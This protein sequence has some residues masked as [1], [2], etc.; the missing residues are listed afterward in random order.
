MDKN[1]DG[2]LDVD[3]LHE[4]REMRVAA[5]VFRAPTN[6]SDILGGL[7]L[8]EFAHRIQGTA[9]EHDNQA[10]L[11][12]GFEKGGP[13]QWHQGRLVYMTSLRPAT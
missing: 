3:E 9:F 1:G 13:A 5:G 8:Q 2:H 10:S 6:T 12:N 7:Q 4:A 11:V